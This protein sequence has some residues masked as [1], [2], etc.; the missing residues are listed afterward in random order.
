MVREK[1]DVIASETN[2][3]N[4]MHSMLQLK[5]LSAIKSIRFKRKL[6]KT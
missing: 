3:E 6:M 5:I 4:N 1:N 2:D